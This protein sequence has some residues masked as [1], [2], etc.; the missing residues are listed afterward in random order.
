MLDTVD[1]GPAF[2]L[3]ISALVLAGVS[4]CRNYWDS[5][6]HPPLPPGPTCLPII[7]SVLSL[8]DPVRPWLCFSVWKAKYGD[9]IYARLL[10]KRILVINSEDIAK[11]LFDGRSQ[12][13]SDKPQ[14]FVFKSFAADFNASVM[15]YGDR[16]RLHRRIFQQPF[17]QAA[18]PTY[19]AVLLRSAH[20]MLFNFLHDPAHYPSHFNMFTSSMI[21]SVVYDHE[22]KTKDDS[23][24]RLMQRYLEAVVSGIT[25]GGTVI[26]E[27]FP[28]LLRL[29]VWFPGA[30]FKRASVECLQAGHDVK[31]IP[32]RSVIDRM[33]KEHVSPCF[34]T[35]TLNKMNGF[36]DKV[37]QAA[38]KEA[39]CVA[40]AG[41]VETTFS[42]LLVFFLAMVLHPE[43]QAKAQAEID[44]VV[45]KDRLPDFDDRPALPY[46]EAIMRETLRWYPVVPLGSPHA[47]TTSDI[48][49]GYF[50]PKGVVVIGNTWAMTHDEEKYPSPHEFKPERFLRDDGSLTSDTMPLGFGWGRRLC[51]GR[52][53]AEAALWVAITSFLA[54]FSVHKA[55][56]EQGE[57]IPIVPKFTTGLV[58]HPE[59]FPCRI[60][61]RF[62]SVE[63]LTQLT[64][65]VE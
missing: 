26:M 4:W 18:I 20:K 42:T 3:A 44:R 50:I 19:H 52:H 14:S 33:S 37:I 7:G 61:P 53:L 63:T 43:V 39:A 65:L 54:S 21:L 27:A 51:V 55:R 34:V 48:Y 12:I 59:T 29:P 16:W 5:R 15:P 28:W 1:K 36:E 11:D 41:G 8:K 30:T 62:Q 64:G 31:E 24:I 32:F 25:P 22:P 2:Y 45:G 13:Y 38:I 46:L 60:V 6:S 17:H 23:I 49:K 40:F 56:D 57:E 9:I 35:D 47:T 10:S 58:I